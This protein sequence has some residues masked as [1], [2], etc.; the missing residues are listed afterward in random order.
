MENII[1]A[2]I[3]ILQVLLSGG[4]VNGNQNYNNLNW[5]QLMTL[6]GNNN[7]YTNWYQSEW[8][9]V[10]KTIKIDDGQWEQYGYGNGSTVRIHGN[11]NTGLY[12]DFTIKGNQ[13]DS[14]KKVT[15]P[16][17]GITITQTS[18]N[19]GDSSYSFSI[20]PVN[21]QTALNLWNMAVS[22]MAS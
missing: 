19:S 20:G 21:F 14:Q 10:D 22:Q 2:I 8:E 15:S 6:L 16:V 11:L 17:E 9:E 4:V 7:A 12:F 18:Y 13:W 3:M 1:V 5:L